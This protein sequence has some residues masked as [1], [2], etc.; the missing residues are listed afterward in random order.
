MLAIIKYKNKFLLQLRD[1]K[2][3]IRDPNMGSFGGS[4]NRNEN[5]LMLSKE[6]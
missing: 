2:D 6:N 5:L 3:H 4:I 1:N